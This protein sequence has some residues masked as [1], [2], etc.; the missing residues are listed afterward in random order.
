M[1]MMDKAF[2]ASLLILIKTDHDGGLSLTDS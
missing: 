2:L 1:I